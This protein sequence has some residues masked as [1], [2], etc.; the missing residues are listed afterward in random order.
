MEQG[1]RDLLKEHYQ[2]MM[3]DI[4]EPHILANG[5]SVLTPV[6]LERIEAETRERGASTGVFELLNRLQKRGP[7]AFP[8]LIE[9][10]RKSK[11]D[12]IANKLARIAESR[13]LYRNRCNRQTGNNTEV[14]ARG[15]WAGPKPPQTERSLSYPVQQQ[16]S[17]NHQDS[18]EELHASRS[19]PVLT[20]INIPRPEDL[21]QHEEK[22]QQLKYKGKDTLLKDIPSSLKDKVV[23]M[24]SVED[25]LGKDWKGIAGALQLTA[26]EQGQIK[27]CSKISPMEE[28][29]NQMLH[30]GYCVVDLIKMLKKIYRFDVI[31][32][33]SKAGYYSQDLEEGVES[34]TQGADDL[35]AKKLD[36]GLPLPKQVSEDSSMEE[37]K[38][39]AVSPTAISPLSP[40]DFTMEQKERKGFSPTASPLSPTD[41]TMEEKKRDDISP[42][43]SPLSPTRSDNSTVKELDKK[44]VEKGGD[45][46]CLTQGLPLP[47]K[48]P[49]FGSD[50]NTKQELDMKKGSS[51][52]GQSSENEDAEFG[53]D[54][55]GDVSNCAE[56]FPSPTQVSEFNSLDEKLDEKKEAHFSQEIEN[57]KKEEQDQSEPLTD[58][59]PF[60]EEV[61]FPD[62]LQSK[63]IFI[64]CEKYKKM[65]NLPHLNK[66][67]KKLCRELE[68]GNWEVFPLKDNNSVKM[69]SELDL[70][71][72]N[73]S[74]TDV[75]L[76]YLAGHTLQ[77]NG[78]NY[79]L[80]IDVESNLAA[81]DIVDS[82]LNINSLVNQ[83]SKKAL[84]ALIIV[85]GGHYNQEKFEC[86]FVLTGL[87]S[88]IPP[89]NTVIAFPCQPGYIRP[90]EETLSYLKALVDII[91]EKK[92]LALTDLFELVRD[93]LKD[94]QSLPVE[95][96]LSSS[97][98]PIYLNTNEDDEG[99]TIWKPDEKTPRRAIVF[100]DHSLHKKTVLTS[101][102]HLESA[103]KQL[104]W[105]VQMCANLK[106]EQIKMKIR[107][108]LKRL[109]GMNVFMLYFIGYVTK[110]K[111]SIGQEN[112]ELNIFAHSQKLSIQWVVNIM[113]EYV[114]GPK[115]LV[116]DD[117]SVPV[118]HPLSTMTPLPQ[119][120]LTCLPNGNRERIREEENS[121]TLLFAQNLSKSRQ[122]AL[123]TVITNTAR[124]WKYHHVNS[125]LFYA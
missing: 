118:R 44:K 93:T 19:T 83:L 75:C 53:S 79:L 2:D 63:A 97:L 15:P 12:E 1:I 121:F 67:T 114:T 88:I 40:T 57:A 80:P 86:P 104:D 77:I 30:K 17:L 122:Y 113:T 70:K 27:S 85:D 46:R 76:V 66:E 4:T 32:E 48:V 110:D 41:F 117:P 74:K 25:A 109:Q 82:C 112:Y 28:L 22:P 81:A 123:K 98:L 5:I 111:H 29:F 64:T 42:T 96:S 35:A 115:I 49:V 72:H 105:Q 60:E 16:T 34:P 54:K 124:T 94:C 55:K 89:P 61:F 120:V 9:A 92:H 6:D 56:S 50:D 20:H 3:R 13:K 45:V 36:K 18:T 107:Q 52:A 71:L 39:D 103:L 116:V 10:L 102:G 106:P 23:N 37:E 31:G 69:K 24:L 73:L 59:T 84:M 108:S 90:K 101:A 47:T 78:E 8:Q 26:E 11:Y 21:T 68:D 38:T 95:F 125:S 51:I 33:I 119:E 58:M 87:T 62:T 100:C 91:K 99:I 43:A 14:V 65:S 7:Q